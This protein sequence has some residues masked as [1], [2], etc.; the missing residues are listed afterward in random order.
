MASNKRHIK[1]GTNWVMKH[2]LRELAIKRCIEAVY[3]GGVVEWSAD[4]N[5]L[6]STCSNVVKVINLDKDLSSYTIGDPD[7]SLRITCICLDKSRSRLIVAYNNQVIREFTV[8]DETPALARTWKTMHTAPILCMKMNSD[9]TLLATGSADHTVKVWD[10]V[11]TALHPHI[12]GCWRSFS[13]IV[14]SQQPFIGWISRG[15]SLHV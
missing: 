15:T 11:L 12:E 8:S 9:G 3:T 1:K 5:T 10:M 6:Y 13:A 7:E 4:G 14:Y 2:A